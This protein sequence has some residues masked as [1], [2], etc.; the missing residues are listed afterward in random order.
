MERKET[1]LLQEISSSQRQAEALAEDLQR[2]EDD[3]AILTQERNSLRAE[4][5]W[6]R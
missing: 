1:Q 4:R 2:R 5:N 6:K 3:V